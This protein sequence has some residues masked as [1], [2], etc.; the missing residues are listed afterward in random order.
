MRCRQPRDRA[1]SALPRLWLLTDERIADDVLLA[2]VARL[3]RGAGIVFRHYSLGRNQRRDL[4]TRVRRIARRR[5]LMLFLAG[6]EDAAI[7]W[8]CNGFHGRTG[9]KA[10]HLLRSAPVHNVPEIRAAE[11]A[12]AQILFLSPLFPT[13]THPGSATLGR[14]RFAR[15]ARQT[16][17][18][19][20]ALGGVTKANAR[21]L[22]ALGAFG[23][24]AIDGLSV[25]SPRR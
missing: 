18:P 14:A 10:V 1:K 6:S 12:G 23:W 22:A 3:P 16:R 2:S 5:R 25:K 11:R 13:R 20:I 15:L 19:V 9:Q 4:F 17:L 21:Q 7:R 8:D 24:A